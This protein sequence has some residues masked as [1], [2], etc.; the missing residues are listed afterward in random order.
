MG[1]RRETPSVDS[2]SPHQSANLIFG[3]GRG[4]LFGV[5][6]DE[7]RRIVLSLFLEPLPVGFGF[8]DIVSARKTSGIITRHLLGKWILI[9]LKNIVCK[10]GLFLALAKSLI[11]QAA[12]Q[13]TACKVLRF[14]SRH[15]IEGLHS[16]EITGGV[17]L[18]T[19]PA[20]ALI[21][22]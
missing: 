9:G 5:K 14:E 1:G 13:I 17:F 22:A 6:L 20:R 2:V 18:F 15:T 11:T 12:L 8:K 16:I 7:F 3:V 10:G 4:S 19:E 21:A